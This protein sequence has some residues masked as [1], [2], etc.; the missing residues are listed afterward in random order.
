MCMARLIATD[1]PQT[2]N[3]RGARSGR[4]DKRFLSTL[5]AF[6]AGVFIRASARKENT[7]PSEMR[8]RL[9]FFTGGGAPPPP[10]ASLMPQALLGVAAAAIKMS[11]APSE[12]HVR[13]H[14]K[15]P[16]HHDCRRPAERAADRR[17]DARRRVVIEDV[18]QIDGRLD[19]R[20]AGAERFREPDVDQVLP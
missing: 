5:S 8:K 20:R 10:R 9:L 6:S 15:E 3:N 16:P 17:H 19:S 18:E 7:V 2:A 14:T 1:V 4:R 11:R 12:C 13:T